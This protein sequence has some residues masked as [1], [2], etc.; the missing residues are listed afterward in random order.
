M[1]AEVVMGKGARAKAMLLEA[2]A[3]EVEMAVEAARMVGMLAGVTEAGE[4]V[5][6]VKVAVQEE[7]KGLRW[8][9]EAE[10]RK[11]VRR[12]SNATRRRGSAGRRGSSRDSR[13]G[14]RQGRMLRRGSSGTRCQ[15]T[16]GNDNVRV[17]V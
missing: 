12:R 1:M 15:G 2:A 8:V 13:G 17:C 7:A 14:S 6:E 10:A 9:V 4:A 16:R 3:P 11:V 5:E